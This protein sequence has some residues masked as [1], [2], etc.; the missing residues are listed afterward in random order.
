MS[1]KKISLKLEFHLLGKTS[2]PSVSF[3][4]MDDYGV[5]FTSDADVPGTPEGDAFSEFSKAAH[6]FCRKLKDAG[7]LG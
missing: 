6:K 2:I 5:P 7:E 1:K 3:I 4:G